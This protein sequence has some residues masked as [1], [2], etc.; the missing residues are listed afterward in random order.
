MDAGQSIWEQELYN[1]IEYKNKEDLFHCFEGDTAMV[2]LSFMDS[3]EAKDF[4]EKVQE[5]IEKRRARA[6]HYAPAIPTGAP[7]KDDVQIPTI[8]S[9]RA[10]EKESTPRTFNLFR[11]KKKKTGKRKLDISQVGAPDTA[12]FERVTGVRVGAGGNFENYE[13]FKGMDPRMKELFA[14]SGLDK[15]VMADPKKVKKIEKLMNDSNI[16]EKMDKREKTKPTK[17]SAPPPPPTRGGVPPPPPPVALPPPPPAP[18]TLGTTIAPVKRPP[19]SPKC[20]R[21]NLLEDIRS[22]TSLKP[23]A[24]VDSRTSNPVTDKDDTNLEDLM[25][26]A[27]EIIKNAHFSSDDDS[28][29]E[30]DSGD[31]DFWEP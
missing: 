8:P 15:S 12:T 31:S 27:L 26:A 24:E 19:P 11:R 20:G 10:G 9:T 25:G 2:G 6:A 5:R 4:D 7:Y 18:A 30:E 28:D 13:N 14:L 22:G 29:G 21:G 16:L 1:E 17:S 23:L 3:E